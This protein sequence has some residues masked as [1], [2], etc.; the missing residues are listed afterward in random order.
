MKIFFGRQIDQLAANN[1]SAFRLGSPDTPNK[2]SM[3][4]EEIHKMS[5]EIDKLKTH[6]DDKF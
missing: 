3:S 2:S 1:N 5:G 6:F 4:G